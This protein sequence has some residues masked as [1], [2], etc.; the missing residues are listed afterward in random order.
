MLIRKVR[1]AITMALAEN[2]G[3]PVTDIEFLL[4]LR[5]LLD[6]PE[7]DDKE[8]VARTAVCRPEDSLG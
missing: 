4:R 8:T 1:H 5:S 7:F 6:E 3:L 2:K